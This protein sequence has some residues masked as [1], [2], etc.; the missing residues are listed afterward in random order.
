MGVTDRQTDRQTD[1]CLP[2]IKLRSS[3]AAKKSKM[4][5]DM[6]REM[7]RKIVR[8]IL[9]VSQHPNFFAQRKSDA[10]IKSGFH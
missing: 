2:V 9:L 8:S 3:V 4:A 10:F 7:V 1:G 6:E 5:W